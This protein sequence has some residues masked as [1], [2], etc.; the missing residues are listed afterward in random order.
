MFNVFVTNL[1][2]YNE[3]E[4][5]G[6]WLALPATD[7]EIA[8]TLEKIG[9]SEEPDESGRIYEEYFITDYEN[10]Y[11]IKVDEYESLT[12]LNEI[13]EKL[14]DVD[15]EQFEAANYYAST[16]EEALDILDDVIYICTPRVFESDEEAVGYYFATECGYLDQVPENLQAYFDFERFGRDIMLEGS[17]Y[18]AKSGAIYEVAR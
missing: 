2:K 6:E 15:A 18:T 5:V 9:I 3:G 16:T 14:E 1:G 4:L 7:A 13:A 17:F 10:D 8:A 11:G 12:S